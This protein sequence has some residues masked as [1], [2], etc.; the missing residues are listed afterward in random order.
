MKSHIKAYGLVPYLI[1]NN[2][3]KILLCLSVASKD[4]WGCLKGSK[5]KN[6]T[7][8]EC[9]KREFF[10]ESS[11]SVEIALFENDFEQINIDKDVGVWLVNADNIEELSRFFDEDTLKDNYL[12]WENSKVK[13]FA[14]NN[15]PRIKT[16]QLSLIKDIKDFLKNKNQHH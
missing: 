11:L 5:N 4:K 1:R 14:L 2:N 10:E 6:E 3:I 8:F 16:K 12:S 15:L 9:A 13:F 7:A